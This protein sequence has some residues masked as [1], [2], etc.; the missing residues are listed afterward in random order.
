MASKL[1]TTIAL[2]GQSRST[3]HGASIPGSK[4]LCHRLAGHKGDCRPTLS[5]RKVTSTPAVAATTIKAPK[6]K[7]RTVRAAKV[8]RQVGAPSKTV[9]T[10]RG[11]HLSGKPS[12]RLA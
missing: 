9:K 3:F 4:S 12:A 8:R 5:G 1:T 2:K 6:G 11:A 10:G 7:V